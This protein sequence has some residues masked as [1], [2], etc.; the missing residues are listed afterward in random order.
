MAN[1]APS[2]P[3]GSM[4]L[5]EHLDELR[6]RLFRSAVGFL[7]AFLVASW[8]AK[9]VVDW[10]LLPIREV[11]PEGET[12][13]FI[14]LTEPM[15]VY[16]KAAGIVAL[17]LGT[18]FF[19]FQAWGFVAPGLY[20]H[21]RRWVVPFLLVGTS[22]FYAGGLFAHRVVVP[23]AARWLIGLGEGFGNNVTLDESF[24]F[25]SRL[26]IGMGFVFEMPILVFFLARI[27][28][29]TPATLMKHFRV[30]VVVILVV[31]AIVTPPD[32]LSMLL[33]AGPVILLYLLGV[34]VA[35]V[36]LKRS[37]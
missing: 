7:L 22:F 35:W 29:V 19:L 6:V 20:R 9:D 21:E 8:F 24:R 28:V 5:L 2:E 15:M 1:P 11:L 3:Q 37:R 25:V 36:S 34:F 17:F 16:L 12:L 13:N 32:P 30:V 4:P 10:L 31:C 18:P 33:M 27:G 23:V 26:V 14:K